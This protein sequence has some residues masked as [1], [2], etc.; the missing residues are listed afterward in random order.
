MPHAWVEMQMASGNFSVHHIRIADR[1]HPIVFPPEDIR[2]NGDT[3]EEGAEIFFRDIDERLAHDGAGVLVVM[4]TDKFVEKG[5]TERLQRPEPWNPQQEFSRLCERQSADALAMPR[6]VDA[7]G[8]TEKKMRGK[9]G[10]QNSE[11]GMIAR[12]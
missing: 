12:Y 11:C 6:M 2:G 8:G 7:C 1:R 5:A 10:I 9:C 4:D 3:R